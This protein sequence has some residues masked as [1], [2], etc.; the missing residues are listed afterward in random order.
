MNLNKEEL[1]FN[2]KSIN[3]YNLQAESKTLSYYFCDNDLSESSNST[4]SIFF[5]AS[6]CSGGPINSTT[7]S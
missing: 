6:S 3:V 2:L 7:S 5:L 1:L 4:G